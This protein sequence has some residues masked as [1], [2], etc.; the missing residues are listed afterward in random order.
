MRRLC[1]ALLVLGAA[2]W[3]AAASATE[4]P[5]V[6]LEI[7]TGCARSGAR[8]RRLASRSSPASHAAGTSTPTQPKQPFLKPTVLTLTVARRGDGRTGQLPAPG[9]AQVRLR[10]RRR[11]AGL[12]RQ[13]RSGDG[14][15][16]ARGLRRRP[17]PHRRGAAVSGVRRHHL[18]APDQRS[19]ADVVLPVRRAR[20]C[21]AAGPDDAA[22]AG[23]RDRRRGGA[24]PL[25]RRARAR[26]S[27]WRR[28]H[29]SAWGSTSRRASIRSSR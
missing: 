23:V 12:R 21:D 10:R 4:E 17:A 11:A 13:A 5:K 24:G 16:R 20:R 22:A 8:R 2:C 18:P 26:C 25:A 14:D 27:R 7:A 15:P 9:H 19:T 3:T 1:L 28:S 29:C 6:S